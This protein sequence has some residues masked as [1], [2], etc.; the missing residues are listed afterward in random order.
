LGDVKGKRGG[1]DADGFGNGA[2]VQALG[3]GLDE[4]TKNRE[5]R[6]LR[7]RGERLG[8]G[9]YFHISII[10]EILPAWQAISKPPAR[11]GLV[12]LVA[13]APE[14]AATTLRLVALLSGLRGRSRGR[15]LA[16][17]GLTAVVLP[18]TALGHGCWRWRRNCGRRCRRGNPGLL[19]RRC[20]PLLD[21]RFLAGLGTRFGAEFGTGSR[22]LGDVPLFPYRWHGL[23]LTRRGHDDLLPGRNLGR[24]RR[25][26][27]LLPGRI[28]L[29]F[30]SGTPLRCRLLA[31]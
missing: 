10:M 23:R 3:A 13:R 27:D 17:L 6:F 14:A 9:F 22:R 19:H 11:I 1:G 30:R 2:G 18:P 28:T 5:A 8:G 21:A 29:G 15:F 25:D 24:T 16:H 20:R 26:D 12:A 4:Q 7:Q 31:L